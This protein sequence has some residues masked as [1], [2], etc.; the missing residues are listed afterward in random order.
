MGAGIRSTIATP[1]VALGQVVGSLQLRSTT[2]Q[3]YGVR[4]LALVERVAAQIAGAV[5]NAQAHAALQQAERALRR[6]EAELRESEARYRTIFE[7][8]PIGITFNPSAQAPGPGSEDVQWTWNRRYEEIVGRKTAAIRQA[9]HG[10]SH[11]DDHAQQE[12]LRAEL[13]AGQR[14]QYQL[15][16]RYLHDDGRV[17]WAQLRTAAVRDTG[18]AGVATISMVEDITERKQAN[19]QVR[20]AQAAR[21]Q[22]EAGAEAAQEADRLKSEL[23]T[24]VSH[25][26]RTPLTS[27]LGFSELMLHRTLRADQI[28]Q[29]ASVMHVEAQRLREVIDNLLDLQRLEASRETYALAPVDLA[30][31]VE[32][33]VRV[34]QG[35]A[36][37][38]TLETEVPEGLPL[39]RADAPKLQ[40]VLA[41][42]VSNAIKYSPEGGE[43]RIA[44]CA[45]DGDLHVTVSDQGL[46]IP[47]EALER[48]FERFYRVPETAHQQ[49]H[50]T[51]LG[52]ALVRE[53][54]VAHEGEVWAESAGV[55]LG[56][57][58][59]LTLPL[60]AVPS[61]AGAPRLAGEAVESPSAVL[62]PGIGT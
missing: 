28:A 23:V 27:L 55:G 60:A 47:A 4:E 61:P 15:E 40:Q 38:H 26:L 41:N 54:I 17:T 42:L 9:P 57:T 52:L 56:S 43:I 19:E 20:Q 14:D 44:A 33:T 6:T 46:G 24:T 29:Y 59:H 30:L 58:F 21:R 1:L 35:A 7:H 32:R 25:E 45:E 16:K 22:A 49:V 2:P 36:R 10:F 34:Y 53:V 13:L 37:R 8:A 51:G 12:R 31:V 50:G 11:P 18:G 5:A 62:A 48:V 39:V 3:A